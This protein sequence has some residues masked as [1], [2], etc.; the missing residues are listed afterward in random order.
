MGQPYRIQ[1]SSSPANGSWTDF[2]NFT[3]TGA[4]VMNEVSAAGTTNRFY[5][6]ITP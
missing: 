4:V 2:T 1:V 6:A 5:R 3:C